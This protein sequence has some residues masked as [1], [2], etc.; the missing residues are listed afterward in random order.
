MT[1]LTRYEK[2]ILRDFA[3]TLIPP[4][5]ILTE[6]IDDVGLVDGVTHHLMCLPRHL[7]T[8]FR[9]V[10]LFFEAGGV[11]FRGLPFTCLARKNKDRY[12]EWWRATHIYPIKLMFKL[13]ES[14]CHMQY[15]AQ[16]SVVKKLGYAPPATTRRGNPPKFF[17]I[18]EQDIFLKADV[19][20]IGS[21]AGGA[22]VAKELAE[23]GRSVVILEEGGYFGIDD[24]GK[25][26]LEIVQKL[27]HNAGMQF[28]LGF[29]SI[30]LPT[31]KAVGGTTIINSGTC[32]KV[33]PRVLARWQ[34]QFGL[35]ELTP[36]NLQPYFERVEKHL[37]VA[38]VAQEVL[39]NCARIFQRG[40][41]KMG[42]QGA[43][44]PRN[45]KECKGA[46]MCCFGCPNDAKQS[47]NLSYIPQAIEKGAKLFTHCKVES[48]IPKQEHGGEVIGYFKGA[49]GIRKIHVD[50]KVV[51]L[52]AGTI[53]TPCLLR[54]NHIA[55]HNRHIGR[56]LTI[57]PTGKVIGFFDEEVR[58]WEGVPQGYS[59][60]GY[61]AEGIMFEGVYTPPSFG[62][63]YLDL[64]VLEH[65][66]AI[67][68]YKHMASFGFL[69]SDNARGWVRSLPN[70]EPI[71][72]YNLK[73]KEVDRFF[74]GIRFLTRVFL[75]AGAKIIYTGI[76]AASRITSEEELERFDQLTINRTD[77]DLSAFHPL[78]TCRMGANPE[79]SVVNHV[80]EMHGVRNLFIADG[81]IFP[82]SLGVNPQ[83]TI[84]A[85]ANRTADYIHKHR[86]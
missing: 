80:G 38:P 23:Q 57:H 52:S 28:T 17:D 35:T 3:D 55:L 63:I 49:K 16:P 24:F 59:Y 12:L 11:L 5:E 13:V 60:D 47:V 6:S 26:A 76:P 82:T 39:G 66:R 1:C 15:Y 65:K 62:S 19:C 61:S 42:L 83:E 58:G 4:T 41:D 36:A 48:I 85:F 45:A 44:L 31:G 74:K 71:I 2:K 79:E 21:G 64:P 70:G 22:V 33:P 77:L 10:L 29:P 20:V 69:I 18:P 75:K 32:L 40:L 68:K 7:R 84:M 37:H 78:G 34:E 67:E 51:V 25:E 73:K 30:V 50:A 81:S 9:M 46:S 53:H 72:Y 86:L 54:K 8:L 14:L 43:P 27:Y 56:H